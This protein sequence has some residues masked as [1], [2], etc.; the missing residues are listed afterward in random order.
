MRKTYM[1]A[2]AVTAPTL[3]LAACGGGDSGSAADEGTNL[4]IALLAPVT[5]PSAQGAEQVENVVQMTVDEINSSGGIDGR[6]LEVSVYDT[7]LTP[8]AA[9]TEAQRAMTQDGV[10]AILGPWSSGEGIAVAQV[11]DRAQTVNVNYSSVDPAVT[12]DKSFVFRVAPQTPEYTA[13]LV[14]LALALDVKSAAVLY[15]S[16][17]FG[18]GVKVPLQAAAESSGLRVTDYIQYTINSSDLSAEVGRAAQGKPGAVFVLGSAGA[19]NGLVGKAMVE[20]GLEVPLLGLS[21][22]MTAD[23][24][25]IGGR[26]FDQLPGAYTVQTVESEKPEYA[27]LLEKYG[28]A[29]GAIDSLPEQAVQAVD[30]VRWLTDA[31]ESSGGECGEALAT[32]L[33]ELPAR[34]G[35]AGRVGSE[36][37]FTADDHNAFEDNYLV[38]YK[39]EGGKPVQATSLQL[40]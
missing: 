38:P 1:W 19:D 27:D 25:A 31:L 16:G 13:G 24:I 4:P 10:C 35:L 33:V 39:I 18:Q 36:Q 34:E 2:A 30:S 22:I 14:E 8:E 17:G 6:N 5:G 37:E 9:T 15:D 21:P 28:E 40:G 20:Q 12:E 7:K 23:S 32:A 29:H 26:A 11:V 3:L